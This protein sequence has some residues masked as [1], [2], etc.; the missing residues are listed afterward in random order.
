MDNTIDQN[1]SMPTSKSSVRKVPVLSLKS[2]TEGSQNDQ[3]KFINELFK[4]GRAHV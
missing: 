3:V 2:Y 4:I 1:T